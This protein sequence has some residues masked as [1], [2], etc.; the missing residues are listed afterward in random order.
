MTSVRWPWTFMPAMPL[1]PALDH[2]A[3]TQSELEGFLAITRAVELGPVLI[4]GA[5]AV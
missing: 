3:C 4:G 2:L 5:R 1:V